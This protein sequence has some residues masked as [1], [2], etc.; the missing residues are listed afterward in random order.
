MG[1]LFIRIYDFFERRRALLWVVLVATVGAMAFFALRIR[2][3]ERITGFF[4]N[5][6]EGGRQAMIFDH[7]KIMDRIVVMFSSPD[8][9]RSIACAERFEALLTSTEGAGQIASIT[10][11]VGS[12]DIA[13]TIDLIY[14][15]LPVYLTEADYRR[16]DSLLATD[17]V[18]RAVTDAYNRLASPLGMAVR[19]TTLA[20]PLNIATGKFAALENFSSIA[21][22]EIYDGR[23]FSP[24]MAT[25][26]VIIEPEQGIGDT[27]SNEILISAIER[28]IEETTSEGFEDVRMEYIGGPSVAVYNARQVKADTSLTLSIALII[29]VVFIFAAFRNRLAVVLVTTPV[30]FGALFAL[31][32]IWLTGQ[33]TVSAIAIGAGAAVL[34]VALSYSIHVISHANHTSDPRRIIRE[35][36]YPLTVGSFTTIGAFLGLLFTGSQLLR[37]LGLFA[38]LTLVGTTLF[39]LIFLPHFLA[40]GRRKNSTGWV[41]RI[42]GKIGAYP[43]D[44]NRGMIWTVVAACVV[45]LFFYGRVGFDSDMMNLNYMP[46]HLKAAEERL[47]SFTPGQERPVLFV[48]TGGDFEEAFAAYKAT[49]EILDSLKDKGLINGFVSAAD[50]LPPPSVQRGRIERWRE[51]W[52]DRR[53]EETTGRIEASAL[54][55]GFR[56]GAFDAFADN[57]DK[58]YTVTDLSA[59]QVPSF[60]AD[61]VSV[62]DDG[63]TML[64]SSVKLAPENKEAVYARFASDPDTVI[65]D[66]SYFAGRMARGVSDDFN[67]ILLVASALIFVALLISYGRIELTL[68]AFMPMLVSWIIILGLMAL[69]GI[70]FNIVSIILSTFIFGI[71]DDFSIFIMEGLLSEYKDGKK[72]LSA[73]K[74]A[75]FFSAFTIIVG[76]GVMILARHPAMHSLAVVS[77]LGILAVIVVAY[78]LQPVVFRMFISSQTRKGG[79]PYTLAALVNSIY[80]FTYFLIGCLVLQAIILVLSLVPVGKK[81]KKLWFHRCVRFAAWFFLETMI[82]VRRVRIDPRGET[83]DKPAVIIANHSSF[84]D[85]LVLLG[86]HPKLVMVTNSWVWRSPFFGRIV[87]YA[88]FYHTADGYDNLADALHEKVADGYSVV[89][90]PEGTRSAD[91]KIG[92]FH[93]GAFHLAEKLGLD[94]LPVVLYGNGLASSKRQPFYIKKSLLVSKILPRITPGDGS[95]G[96]TYSERAKRIARYFR[97]EYDAVYEE[98]NRTCNPYFYD[99]LI[100]SYTYKGPVLEWYM[101]VKVG[102]EK[103]YDFFDRLVPREGSVV[104]IG[105]GYGALCYMLSMLSERRRVLGI[106]YDEEKIAV[107]RHSFLHGER[108][109]FVAADALGFDLPQADVFIL[110]DVL[111]Y[112]PFERQDA[113]L[114]RCFSLAAPGGM[115]IVRDGDSSERE[116]HRATE[117]TEKWSTR[118]LRFNKTV[119]ELHF[120]DSERIV[121][122]ARKAGFSVKIV[123]DAVK[124]SNKIYICTMS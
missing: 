103:S 114:E 86:L 11:D 93:K 49:D 4:R 121:S 115:V 36:A 25:M 111:H 1:D 119:G 23:I 94:I 97:R 122:A 87:R 10:S 106:D 55:N 35:L 9:D 30:I 113:L 17:G 91:M 37:D 24:D 16:I 116:R 54:A 48:S 105:C 98:Y 102:M 71:G 101:R 34:G 75:I 69:L 74:T 107:A 47:M 59:G 41:G 84:I 29:T 7:L 81:R 58:N 3:D 63:T 15:N 2:Y 112:M 64:V 39:C 65:V 40:G 53:R 57:L 26:L 99:A 42:I 83:F 72:M 28:S 13:G 66:R 21:D 67:L 108:T 95:F 78:V 118:L 8:P 18:E 45:C 124:T 76:L 44:R 51:F 104:D 120:T 33:H 77:I 100:K 82:T 38:A 90:F 61:R 32:I 70:E 96:G 62:A 12:G 20:D 6:D 79:F 88:D 123:D 50:F 19:E 109:S 22:Y 5:G 117:R 110:N 85:I 27:G 52:S 31:G 43:Y 73:H 56:P 60:L 80:A 89:V 68:M 46:P 14:G 92:R